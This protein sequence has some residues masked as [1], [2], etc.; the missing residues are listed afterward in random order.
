M[1]GPDLGRYLVEVDTAEHD[2]VK[3]GR[4]ATRTSRV[5][6]AAANDSDAVLIA[7]QMATCTSGG[8]PTAARL[9]DFPT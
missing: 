8:M 7:A 3:A 6:L 1:I 9:L 4:I 5:A 2:D